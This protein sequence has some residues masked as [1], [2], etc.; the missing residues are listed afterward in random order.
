MCFLKCFRRSHK[1][2][3]LVEDLCGKFKLTT[4]FFIYSLCFVTLKV[5]KIVILDDDVEGYFLS[6]FFYV[7]FLLLNLLSVQCF[8]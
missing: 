3:V 5:D 1:Y 2:F 7:C 4:S 8:C 6:S